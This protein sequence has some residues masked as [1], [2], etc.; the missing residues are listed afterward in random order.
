M[1]GITVGEA[2][3]P[4]KAIPRAIRMTFWRI[5]FFY[6][7]TVFLLGLLVP[8]NSKELI[9]ANKAGKTAAASPFVVA[10]RLAGIPKLPG[11]M[12]GC[13]MIFNLSASTSDLYIA[14]RTLYSMA[15]QGHAPK[16][17]SHTNERK[18]PIWSF[19]IC[20]L[21]ALISLM[22]VSTSST[23]VF[24]YFVSLCEFSHCLKQSALIV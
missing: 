5:A 17:L 3:N 22:N 8:Y 10:I 20:A 21:L 15:V 14:T 23:I 16:F 4:R 19:I 24:G 6:V 1:V 9:F 2:Q 11:I 13:I 18:L 7:V 12:N